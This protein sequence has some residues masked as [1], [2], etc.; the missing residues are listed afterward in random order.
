V[1][2]HSWQASLTTDRAL[3]SQRAWLHL[4]AFAALPITNRNA[5]RDRAHQYYETIG[6]LKRHMA[7]ENPH[8]TDDEALTYILERLP[9]LQPDDPTPVLGYPIR[10]NVAAELEEYR[11][12]RMSNSNPSAE[13][14]EIDRYDEEFFQRSKGNLAID[15]TSTEIAPAEITAVECLLANEAAILERVVAALLSQIVEHSGKQFA[16]PPT[17]DYV[18]SRYRC[19]RILSLDRAADGCGLLQFTFAI[20]VRDEKDTVLQVTIHRDEVAPVANAA[21]AQSSDDSLSWTHPEMGTFS[22]ANDWRKTIVLPEY[23]AFKYLDDGRNGEIEFAIP[24]WDGFEDSDT[25]PPPA[26]EV[27]ADFWRN[28]PT[29]RDICDYLLADFNNEWKTGN[30]WCHADAWTPHNPRPASADD[31]LQRLRLHQIC[32]IAIDAV[33]AEVPQDTMLNP[34]TGEVIK[35]KPKKKGP[36]RPAFWAVHLSLSADFEEEHGLALLWHRGRFIGS[37]YVSDKIEPVKTYDPRA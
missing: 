27:L 26:L 6:I 21:P 30:W 9:H 3:H 14:L 20:P 34:F 32:T 37:G 22:Q 25:P 33:T 13:D 7:F 4:P 29:P 23:A 28:R 36:P 1:T 17:V 11:Q 5:K 12:E 10:E 31:L 19:R 18:R 15:F 2:N 35:I 16:K 8:I 24:T